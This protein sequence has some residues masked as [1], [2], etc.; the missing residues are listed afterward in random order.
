MTRERL[1]VAMTRGRRI[2]RVY[3]ALDAIDPARD[4]LPD[5]HRAGDARDILDRTLATSGAELSATQTIARALDDVASLERFELIRATLLADAATR[6]WRRT[7]SA[8]GL[9]DSRV[10]A[11]WGSADRAALVSALR[12]GEAAGHPMPELVAWIVATRGAETD[13]TLA[14]TLTTRL[15]D[16]LDRRTDERGES[17]TTPGWTEPVLPGDPAARSLQQIDALYAQRLAEVIARRADDQPDWL[18][19]EPAIDQHL[20]PARSAREVAHWDAAT[21]TG[22]RSWPGRTQPTTGP[23]R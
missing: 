13:E 11:I 2:N 9:S 14:R 15:T 3:V 4:D 19:P 10:D 17:A 23:T 5:H 21:V 20:E 12:R 22:P 1:Y 16:W 6:R 7:L 18:P 8:C